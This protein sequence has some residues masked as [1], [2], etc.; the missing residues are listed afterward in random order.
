MP[1]NVAAAA[2]KRTPNLVDEYSIRLYNIHILRNKGSGKMDKIQKAAV[3]GTVKT[4]GAIV[5]AVFLVSAAIA[6]LNARRYC[7]R[8]FSLLFGNGY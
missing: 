3:I 5:G 4:I 7:R 8:N 6:L 2:L 1:Q